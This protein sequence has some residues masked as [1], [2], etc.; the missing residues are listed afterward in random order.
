MLRNEPS[1]TV[2]LQP[3]SRRPL[4]HSLRVGLLPRS[5]I[6]QHSHR[7]VKAQDRILSSV[8]KLLGHLVEFH[9]VIHQRAVLT[10][11]TKFFP[12]RPSMR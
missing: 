11:A 12:R 4:P 6:E 9:Q 7:P 1:L 10:D 8:L 5:R 3:R 2:G